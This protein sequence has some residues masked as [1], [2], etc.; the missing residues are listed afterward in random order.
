MMG[1]FA[2][3]VKTG[4]K[5]KRVSV[6]AKGPRMR[7]SVFSGSKEKTLTGL[8]KSDLIKNKRGKIVTKA[9]AA[10][11]KK[12]YANI[13]GWTAACKKAKTQLGLTGF[14]AIKKGSPVYKAAK[15]IF[16]A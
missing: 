15:E 6:I 14:I 16:S 3:N 13:S 5:A 4:K 12:A 7:A 11:G 2:L 10:A 9:Q 8:K 1:K